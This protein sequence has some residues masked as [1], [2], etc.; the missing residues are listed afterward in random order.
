MSFAQTIPVVPS[1]AAAPW[2]QS[3]MPVVKA[4]SD[5]PPRPGMLSLKPLQRMGPVLQFH[6]F[7]ADYLESLR[8]GDAQTQEHFVCYF[9]ELL[10]LKLRSRLRSPQAIEDV[11]QETFARVLMAIRKEGSLRQP[12]RLGPFVNTVCNNVLLEHY[13]QSARSDSLDEEGASE[14]IAP[15]ASILDAVQSKQIDEQVRKTLED[16]GDHDRSL[17]KAVFLDE[18]DRDEVCRE[19]GV[20][21]DYLRVLLH[22]AKH[23]FKAAY[24]KKNGNRLPFGPAAGRA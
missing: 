9:T 20:D 15:G 17:L 2:K 21:R 24:L 5:T 22:R 16:L 11:R 3:H 23:V 10:H 8:A 6:A 4:V 12:D 1:S 19:F 18:R 14:P 13:R 7:D